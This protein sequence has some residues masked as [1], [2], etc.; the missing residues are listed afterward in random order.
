M[1]I[2][3]AAIEKNLNSLVHAIHGKF[4]DLHLKPT[5]TG[6]TASH[7]AAK[8]GNTFL[9]NYIL[10]KSEINN[11]NDKILGKLDNASKN[12]YDYASN[13]EFDNSKIL[14]SL[15]NYQY[16]GK[17]A[18][19]HLKTNN[20]EQIVTLKHSGILKQE[21]IKKSLFEAILQKNDHDAILLFDNLEDKNVANTE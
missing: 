8:N 9:M 1:T 3:H 17:K 19:D 10:T 15:E 2:Y 12:T 13:V 5:E 11:D 16:S 20:I 7:L 18:I 14:K 4:S 6:V 21:D